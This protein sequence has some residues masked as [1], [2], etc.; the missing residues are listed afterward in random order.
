MV[1]RQQRSVTTLSK[2]SG[3]RSKTWLRFRRH[4]L[5]VVALVVFGIITL[6]VLVGPLLSPYDPERIDF[7]SKAEG[8]SLKHPMGTDDLG[9]DQLVRVLVGGRLTLAVALATVAVALLLGTVI[10]ATAGYG[11]GWLDNTLMRLVDVFYLLPGL[12]VLVLVV[13]M[14]GATFWT[15]VLTLALLRW[16]ST[17]RLVRSSFLTL[18]TLEFVEAARVLGASPF[19]I[20]VKHVLPNALGPMIVATTLGMA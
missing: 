11:G 14:L 20:V 12:F 2:A 13:T 6:A 4:R 1:A 19:R 7:S 5:A 17:A 8:P 9:R 10:G 16:M 18:K 15:L 3:Q